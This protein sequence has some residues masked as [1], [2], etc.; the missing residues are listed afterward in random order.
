MD[1]ESPYSGYKRSLLRN[2]YYDADGSDYHEMGSL[3]A[4]SSRLAT[5]WKLKNAVSV[6]LLLL[7]TILIC[8]V[9]SSVTTSRGGSSE[10]IVEDRANSKME[11]PASVKPA[12]AGTDTA[13][14]SVPSGTAGSAAVAPV[15]GDDAPA[16]TVAPVD[17]GA[18]EAARAYV[19]TMKT[20]MDASRDPCNDF[21]EYSCGGWLQQEIPR[22]DEKISRFYQ[23]SGFLRFVPV[24]SPLESQLS[25]EKPDECVY[26]SFSTRQGGEMAEQNNNV[27]RDILENG[28]WPVSRHL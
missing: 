23:V 12:D 18:S 7:N 11:P 17:G 5:C 13:A 1:V 28:K 14:H 16:P 15:P 24:W 20:V 2:E 4:G 25:M 9:V 22:T 27:L 19:E 10:T 21:Y 3:R 6:V 26:A 8:V